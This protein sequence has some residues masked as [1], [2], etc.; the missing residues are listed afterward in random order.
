MMRKLLRTAAR[1][2][3]LTSVALVGIR[4]AP[5]LNLQPAISAVL[6]GSSVILMVNATGIMDLYAFQFDLSF[7][8]TVLAANAV[9]EGPFLGRGGTT[10]FVPGRIDNRTGAIQMTIAPLVGPVPGL[11]G[12]GSL[13]QVSFRTAGAGT[14]LV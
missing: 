5:L 8:P 9:E 1:F 2:A 6:P 10:L 14:S 4:G 7:V 12:D 11:S 3:L 13:A